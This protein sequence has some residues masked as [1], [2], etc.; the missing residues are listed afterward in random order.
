[1]DKRYYCKKGK[2]WYWSTIERE[3]CGDSNIGGKYSAGINRNKGADIAS[4]DILSFNDVD[5]EYHPQRNELIL[6]YFKA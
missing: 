2:C 6:H 5:D 3:S 4:G 1:M